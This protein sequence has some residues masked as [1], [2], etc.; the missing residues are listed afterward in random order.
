MSLLKIERATL[1]Q[2]LPGLDA[3][4]SAVPLM[5]LEQPGGAAI[6]AYRDYGGAALVIPKS[7]GG[8]GATPL[9]AARIHRALGCRA[10]S[11][12]VAISMHNFSA[13]T[14][15]EYS[16]FG[17]DE[18]SSALLSAVAENKLL[19]ASGFAEG[20]SGVSFMNSTMEARATPD[21]GYVV[22]GTKKPCSLTQ[23][24]DLL[25]GSA[26]LIDPTGKEPPRR[27]VIL[28]PADAPG[29]VRRPFWSSPVLTGAESDE[30][31]LDDVVIP[32]DFLFL[33]QCQEDLDPVEQLGYVWL[34]IML[35]ASYL[36]IVSALVERVLQ[37]GK[38]NATERELL[39]IEVEGAMS[40]I[41]GVAAAMTSGMKAEDLLARVFFVRYATQRAIERAAMSAAELLGGISF[42]SS[43][44]IAYLLSAARALAF[45]PPSRLSS[46][47]GLSS[48]MAGKQLIAV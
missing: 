7:F 48:Y 3:H 6:R 20:R 23:S 14:L 4:L 28:V 24:M 17:G 5:E 47:E 45:H 27:A 36:G 32:G 10:P 30:L 8:L 42:M 26:S 18:A 13:G 22:R 9:E 46:A 43:P 1:E 41:E 19:L 44:D 29:I 11:M 12:A 15:V 40:M 21:G 2:Y 33:T 38:G 25:T 35:G 31:I 39:G 34:Q 37:Q 16:I